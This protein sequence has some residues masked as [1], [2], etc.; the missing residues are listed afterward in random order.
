[1]Y[2]RA[3]SVWLARSQIPDAQATHRDR[4]P[5]AAHRAAGEDLVPGVPCHCPA[6]LFPA[7]SC[8]RALGSLLHTCTLRV[9]AATEAHLA[10][11]PFPS[12]VLLASCLLSLHIALETLATV[13]TAR[14]RPT[15]CSVLRALFARPPA[16]PPAQ[17]QT[18]TRQYSLPASLSSILRSFNYSA[19]VR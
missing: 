12:N 16:R 17:S 4:A 13:F 11:R 14:A 19:H 5:A 3:S 15:M 9:R 7:L 10:S 6:F 8:P 18:Q 2:S 1:M